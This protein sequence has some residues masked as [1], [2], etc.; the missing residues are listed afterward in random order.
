MPYLIAL[1]PILAFVGVVG[2]LVS[3]A[4]GRLR[5]ALALG[6]VGAGSIVYAIAGYYGSI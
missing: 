2:A 6:V 1:V 3:L 5:S 4:R